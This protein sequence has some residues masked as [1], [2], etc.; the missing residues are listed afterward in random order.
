MAAVDQRYRPPD[1]YVIYAPALL[2]GTFK[3]WPQE[4][5]HEDVEDWCVM[6]DGRDLLITL[7]DTNM[8]SLPASYLLEFRALVGVFKHTRIS[9]RVRWAPDDWRTDPLNEACFD[10]LIVGEQR[11]YGIDE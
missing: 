1:Q 5:R 2:T 11:L 4:W 6:P 3:T 9:Y 8:L 7:S 10:Q